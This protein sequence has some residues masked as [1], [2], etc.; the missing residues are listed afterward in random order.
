MS[1]IVAV[2]G[3]GAWGTALGNLIEQAGGHALRL[4]H[5]DSLL[6]NAPAAVVLAVPAQRLRGTLTALKLP[7]GV[8][9]LLAA[10][11]IELDTGLLLHE[12]AASVCPDNP[13][14]LLSGPSFAANV[15]Q[16]LPV[17][18]T[19]AGVGAETLTALFNSR[20]CRVYHSDDAVGVAVGGALKNVMAIGCGI[21]VGAGYGESARAALFTRGLAEMVRFGLALGAKADTFLGLSGVGDMVLTATSPLSRNYALGLKIGAGDGIDGA[22]LTEG[23][24]TA[25][26]ALRRAAPLALSLPITS[27]VAAIVAGHCTVIDAVA[28]LL[29][30]PAGK[31]EGAP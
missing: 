30:R 31:S 13:A 10:K 29:D 12:V 14:L 19:L 5:N 24:A 25:S 22:A 18:L 9:L 7:A 16:G 3:Q 28:A 1:K 17:A 27:A 26:A 20:A 6:E 23:V 21:A 2:I 11:G 8:P 15:M 4:H